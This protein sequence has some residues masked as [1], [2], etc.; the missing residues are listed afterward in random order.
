MT[1]VDAH[2]ELCCA[3]AS[4][5]Q[6]RLHKPAVKNYNWTTEE[7]KIADVALKPEDASKGLGEG[8]TVGG[9]ASAKLKRKSTW[10]LYVSTG[11]ILGHLLQIDTCEVVYVV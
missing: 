9:D 5:H 2:V 6:K 1:Q 3:F 7:E 8:E 4:P 11:P 10:P